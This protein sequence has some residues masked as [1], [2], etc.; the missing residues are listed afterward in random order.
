MHNLSLGEAFLRLQLKT[1]T[2]VPVLR[3]E[4][5]FSTHL[6]DKRN[7]TAQYQMFHQCVGTAQWQFKNIATKISE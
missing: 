7:Q 4:N 3:E 1:S 2:E 5:N 6:E